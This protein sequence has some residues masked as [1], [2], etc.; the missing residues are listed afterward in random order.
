M[1]QRKRVSERVKQREIESGRVKQRGRE[2]G[3]V[4]VRD[5]SETVNELKCGRSE[6]MSE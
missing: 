1:K 4:R 5:K 2:S 3:R 6:I